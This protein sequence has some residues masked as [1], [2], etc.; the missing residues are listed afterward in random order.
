MSGSGVH[1]LNRTPVQV[2]VPRAVAAVWVAGQAEL[3][4]TNATPTH[5]QGTS[6][7]I[8]VTGARGTA[9]PAALAAARA[10][11]AARPATA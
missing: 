8:T 2:I 4:A 3:I 9:R 5:Q 1:Q 6:V 10:T 11:F 7:V